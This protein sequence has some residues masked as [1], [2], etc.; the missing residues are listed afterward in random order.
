MLT[1]TK[2]AI[3]ISIT[4]QMIVNAAL[5]LL[6]V[7]PLR[8]DIDME[9]PDDGAKVFRPRGPVTLIIIVVVSVILFDVAVPRVLQEFSELYQLSQI[10]VIVG[11]LPD[12]VI[13]SYLVQVPTSIPGTF[14]C[15]G[16]FSFITLFSKLRIHSHELSNSRL[17]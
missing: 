4:S 17:N 3:D 16:H 12:D 14:Y 15:M 10:L 7:V 13:E 2:P 1:Q 8:L 6:A 11:Y 9:A 5:L